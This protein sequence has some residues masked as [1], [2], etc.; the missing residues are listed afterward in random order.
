MDMNIDGSMVTRNNYF[1]LFGRVSFKQCLGVLN[2]CPTILGYPGQITQFEGQKLHNCS[3]PLVPGT[4]SFYLVI[5]RGH[6]VVEMKLQSASCSSPLCYLPDSPLQINLFYYVLFQSLWFTT[7]LSNVGLHACSITSSQP[8]PK[9]LFLFS[10]S[11][12]PSLPYS[13]YSPTLVRSIQYTYS[14]LLLLLHF[15][16]YL[17]MIFIFKIML[18]HY[19]IQC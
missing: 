15:Y 8:P 6:R 7:L 4:S 11:P 19:E 13:P 1:T 12:S 17:A 14:Q 9:C 16:F 18:N 5:L 10:V 3:Y 2:S